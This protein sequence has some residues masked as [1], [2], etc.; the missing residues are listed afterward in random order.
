LRPRWQ[1]AA[2]ARLERVR[3]A[4]VEREPAQGSRLSTRVGE[5]RRGLSGLAGSVKGASQEP[6]RT[7]KRQIRP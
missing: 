5:A 7:R 4:D 6:E 2:Y 3:L 1:P